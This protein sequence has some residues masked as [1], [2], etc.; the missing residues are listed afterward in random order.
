MMI[1]AK[2]QPF[3]RASFYSYPFNKLLPSSK[4]KT[5]KKDKY[6]IRTKVLL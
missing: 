5:S 6:D 1:N 4:T 2:T 3:F